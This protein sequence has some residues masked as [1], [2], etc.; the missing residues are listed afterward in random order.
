MPLPDYTSTYYD[1]FLED[2]ANPHTV[3]AGPIGYD[4]DLPSALAPGIPYSTLH[5]SISISAP[6]Q[7]ASG[8]LNDVTITQAAPGGIFLPLCDVG[9]TA[10]TARYTGRVGATQ[11]IMFSNPNGIALAQPALD[12]ALIPP[13]GVGAVTDSAPYIGHA[14]GNY[15]ATGTNAPQ[16]APRRRTRPQR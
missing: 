15:Q 16:T 11:D 5:M 3:G 14:G 13:C 6:E 10:N 9:A 7:I 2:F 8:S 12:G 4:G 1:L